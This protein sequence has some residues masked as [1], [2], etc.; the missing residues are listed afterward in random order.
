MGA[1]DA[2]PEAPCVVVKFSF[3]MCMAFLCKS[4]RLFAAAIA[5]AGILLLFYVL[6]WALFPEAIELDVVPFFK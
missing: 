1:A 3:L 6:L 2:F 4:V 5:Y